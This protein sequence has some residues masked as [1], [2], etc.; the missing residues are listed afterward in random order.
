MS[1]PTGTVAQVE[2]YDF[3][4]EWW[5]SLMNALSDADSLSPTSF[6]FW[7][8]LLTR[9]ITAFVI[10]PIWLVL[11]VVSVG[12]LWPPQVRERVLVAYTKIHVDALVEF[13]GETNK[14]LSALSE[15]N[16][17]LKAEFAELNGMIKKMLDFQS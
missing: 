3:G 13:Q 6:E 4:K 11:G 14:S 2:G 1:E 10:V 5:D 9:I 7:I 17:K 15:S 16:Q 12:I 8:Y